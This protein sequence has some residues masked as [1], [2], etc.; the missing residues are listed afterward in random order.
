MR[1]EAAFKKRLLL[2]AK[3]E[4]CIGKFAVF[5]S[6]LLIFY[7][8]FSIDHPARHKK[9][10]ATGLKLSGHRFQAVADTLSMQW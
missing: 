8:H 1:N 10:I 6:S 2:A 9:A 3:I 7:R 4:T 5:H